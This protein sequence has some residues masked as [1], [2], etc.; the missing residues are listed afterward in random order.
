LSFGFTFVQYS[1]KKRLHLLPCRVGP[2]KPLV[3]ASRTM[4]IGP[5]K[6][7][8]ARAKNSFASLDHLPCFWGWT[9][10]DNALD[11]VS[12]TLGASRG[13]SQLKHNVGTQPRRASGVNRE[14][15]TEAANRRWLQ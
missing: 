9:T 12:S 4:P 14:C 15:G 13:F 7:L 1:L 8:D 3:T 2:I 5:V 10:T 11:V 6:R